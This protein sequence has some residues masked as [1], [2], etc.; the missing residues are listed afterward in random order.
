MTWR[1]TAPAPVIRKETAFALGRAVEAADAAD[2]RGTGSAETLTDLEAAAAL[3][4]A[5][6]GTLSQNATRLNRAL[7]A[8]S[9]TASSKG[10]RAALSGLR[11]ELEL[12]SRDLAFAPLV[13]SPRPVGFP[14][15]TVVGE[16]EVL[17][18]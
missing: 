2:A 4:A 14:E 15:A 18:A 10:A 1:T 16:F 17:A 12:V 5:S 13:E 11:K 6:L 8:A 9:M 7:T 3:A